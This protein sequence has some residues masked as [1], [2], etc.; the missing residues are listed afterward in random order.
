VVDKESAMTF[1]EVGVGSGII[2]IML[3]KK[4]PNAKIIAV[5][6]SQKALDVADKNIKKFG[7]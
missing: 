2:S 5:D 3:A 1:V 4:F 6:I 7:E